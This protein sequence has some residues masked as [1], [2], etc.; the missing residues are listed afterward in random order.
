MIQDNNKDIFFEENTIRNRWGSAKNTYGF[1]DR[2]IKYL[3]DKKVIKNEDQ[4][5]Y[6]FS[7]FIIIAILLSIVLIRNYVGVESSVIDPN[8][9]N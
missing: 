5:L 2:F 8:L 1:F 3:I 7:I 9:F 6:L 4:A